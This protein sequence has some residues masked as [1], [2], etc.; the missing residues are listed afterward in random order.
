MQQDYYINLHRST[1]IAGNLYSEISDLKSELYSDCVFDHRM[2]PFGVILKIEFHKPD[3]NFVFEIYLEGKYPFEPPR[4]LC[5]V[6]FV[7]PS[8]SDGR[9]ILADILTEK[10]S[11]KI[12]LRGL[13]EKLTEFVS[14]KFNREEI[15]NLGK[16][17]LRGPM[18]LT[19]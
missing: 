16:F 18:S 8:I 5:E 13:L 4:I 10:W 14:K 11:P 6:G 2:S 15:L 7:E 19:T 1:I 9:D 12:S 3:N 17:H